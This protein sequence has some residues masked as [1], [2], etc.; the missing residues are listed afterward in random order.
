MPRARTEEV[1]R[2]APANSAARHLLCN[3]RGRCYLHPR[4]REGRGSPPSHC[5][6]PVAEP[7]QQSRPLPHRQCL[8]AQSLPKL[9]TNRDSSATPTSRKRHGPRYLDS[10][11]SPLI[12]FN[13]PQYQASPAYG[14][15]CDLVS[16]SGHP[17][18]TFSADSGPHMQFPNILGNAFRWLGGWP[19]P[20]LRGPLKDGVS[21]LLALEC[22]VPL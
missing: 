9:S 5:I 2:G 3:I 6:F 12:S 8:A 18:R 22:V 14:L 17:G 13:I 4:P 15:A 20:S 19:L 16:C 11:P 1:T 10:G 21:L 7:L